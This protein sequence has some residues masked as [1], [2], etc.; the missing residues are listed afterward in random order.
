MF[1]EQ[2]KTAA[3]RRQSTEFLTD[4]NELSDASDEDEEDSRQ[5]QGKVALSSGEE[6]NN[7]RYARSSTC[8]TGS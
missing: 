4:D 7:I 8:R 1:Q 2:I 3:V 5:L 6:V